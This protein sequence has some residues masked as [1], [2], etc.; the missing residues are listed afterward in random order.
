MLLAEVGTARAALERA[1][2]GVSLA[3]PEQEVV[4]DGDGWTV[5]FRA[6]LPVE[7]HNAQISLLTGVVAARMM[8]DAGVG[9]LRTMPPADAES[10]DRLRRQARALGIPWP[11]GADYG[12]VLAA[13]DHDRPETGAF[14][15][16]ATEPLPRRRLDDVRRRAA[17]GAR[18]RRHRRA[19]R[20]RHRTA[21]PPRRPLRARGLPRGVRRAGRCRPGCATPCPP[22]GPRWPR[23][24][25]GGERW[26]GR[27]RTSWR[28][29]C[30]R[31]RVGEVI[32]AV[33][34]TEG[35]VQLPTRPSSP[36][37]T[38]TPLPAGQDVR[39][40]LTEADLDTRTVRFTLPEP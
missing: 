36:A 18:A 8:L 20:P 29:R 31:P 9:M 17:R 39:V 38:A 7:E 22:S 5:C 19:V 35:S 4:P 27:A 26:T 12:D 21:A 40:R 11:D 30:S 2:G 10:L 23:A 24:P 14:L 34:L 37:A 3:R 28:P 33:A 13:L 1:R 6:S 25:S 32:D 15:A 16:A